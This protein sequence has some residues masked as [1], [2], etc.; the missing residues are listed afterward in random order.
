MGLGTDTAFKAFLK[1][2][3]VEPACNYAVLKGFVYEN[4]TQRLHPKNKTLLLTSPSLQTSLPYR[5][6]KGRCF[7]PALGS[8][9]D[10]LIDPY[11]KMLQTSSDF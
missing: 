1:G 8:I 2:F 10:C 9:K 11:M 6:R 5:I 7:E 3:I 4:T